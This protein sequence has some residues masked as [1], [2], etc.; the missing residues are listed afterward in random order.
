MNTK[1]LMKTI[2]VWLALIAIIFSFVYFPMIAIIT[3]LV[4]ILG[5]ISKLLYD[6]FAGIEH[7]FGH[8]PSHRIIN[9]ESPVTQPKPPTEDYHA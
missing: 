8:I 2:A 3:M 1:A 6:M 5:W 7:N 4:V 9:Q